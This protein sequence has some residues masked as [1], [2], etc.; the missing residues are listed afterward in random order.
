MS[1]KQLNKV[2]KRTKYSVYGWIREREKKLGL[3]NIPSMI[4]AICILYFR[5]N[6]IFEIIDDEQI[7][8]SQ[9]KKT[10]KKINKDRRWNNNSYGKTK[11]ESMNNAIYEWNIKILNSG[12][13][14]N[15][16]IGIAHDGGLAIYPSQLIEESFGHSGIYYMVLDHGNKYSNIRQKHKI[17]DDCN[18]RFSTGDIVSLRLD[19]R[20]SV[21]KLSVNENDYKVIFKNIKESFNV[22]YRLFVSLYSVDDSVEILNFVTM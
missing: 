3:R 15:I 14:G 20:D 21:I 9:Y 2:N 8:I 11:I 10:I 18:Y 7:Q 22:S 5:D 19:L 1:L 13:S 17:E 16:A 4:T 12:A 6:E